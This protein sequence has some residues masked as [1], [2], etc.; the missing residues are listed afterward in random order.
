MTTGIRATLGEIV[1]QVV[2]MCG[3]LV[4][5]TTAS[6][7]AAGTVTIGN[8]PIKAAAALDDVFNNRFIYII[9]GTSAGD[10]RFVDD[11][12]GATRVVTAQTNFPATPTSTSE[13][14]MTER[15]MPLS[16]ERA[17]KR[18]IR[19]ASP[20]FPRPLT[21]TSL[22][23]GNIL[24]DGQFEFW[25]NASNVTSGAYKYTGAGASQGWSVQGTSAIGARYGGS[26]AEP[27][28]LFS[29]DVFARYVG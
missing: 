2:E 19:R 27:S 4:L 10:E 23:V 29:Q 6:A 8:Y 16:Y 21:D 18:A 28:G 20:F 5:R 1:A 7:G 14:I 26:S 9:A 13:L 24:Q 22:R 3:D 25:D 11:Y 17:V 15:R 12:A